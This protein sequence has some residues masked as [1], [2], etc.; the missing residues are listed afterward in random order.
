MLRSILGVIAGYATMFVVV[1]LSFTVGYIALGQSRVLHTGT[2][3][4][5]GTWLAFALVLSAIAA[6]AG[7]IVCGLITRPSTK[8]VMW[9]AIIC[10]VLGLLSAIV[11]VVSPPPPPPDPLPADITAM[12]AAGYA[13]QPTWYA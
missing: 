13:R 6:V 8:P 9:L 4:V 11:P 10:L 1:F 12:E 2:L 7:G 3:E 5:P